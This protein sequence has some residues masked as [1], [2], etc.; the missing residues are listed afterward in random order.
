MVT[1]LLLFLEFLHLPR[2]FLLFLYLSLLLLHRFVHELE[3]FLLDGFDLS[4][5]V[6]LV[7]L[8][9]VFLLL[10]HLIGLGD[11]ETSGREVQLAWVSKCFSVELELSE[12]V[13]HVTAG[14]HASDCW[15]L[16]FLL[17]FLI[18]AVVVE[19]L[20][21]LGEDRSLIE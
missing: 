12:H 2:E 10:E 16:I 13:V 18:D 1:L 17:E 9:F 19:C 8:P 11:E 7:L 6:F 4:R 20:Y 5:L 14:V 3:L 15:K 21:N